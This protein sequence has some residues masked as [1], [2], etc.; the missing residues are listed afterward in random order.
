M[1]CFL[2]ID[3][4]TSFIKAA[5]IDAGALTLRGSVRQP[6]PEFLAGLSLKHRE[7]DPRAVM[8]AVESAIQGLAIDP[9]ACDGVVLC[10]QMHGFVLVDERGEAVSNYISW[11]DQ[12][13]SPE[14]FE[15]IASRVSENERAEL[16]N[17][18]RSSI[19]LSLLYWLRRH[20][21]LPEGGATPVSIADYVAGR[22]C[23]SPPIMEPTQ[24]AAFGALRLGT[25]DWHR[26]VIGKLGLEALRWPEVRPTG[27]VA[28]WWNNLPCYAAAGDQQ[29]ALAGAL[30]GEAELS[31]NI[32][33]GS[34][35]ALIAETPQGGPHQTRPYFDGRFLRTITHIPGG[36]ALRALVGLLTEL[37]GGDEEEAWRKI[38]EAAAAA[39]P[40]DLRAHIAFFPGPCGERGYLENLHEGNLSVAGVFRAVFE[41]MAR[42]YETCARRLDPE[43]LAKRVV[44]SGG[45]ARRFA[46]LRE[47]TSQRLALADRLS[48]HPEDTLF[49]MLVLGLGYS[50]RHGSV[51]EATESIAASLMQTR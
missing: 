9:A 48:P 47:L 49:G 44:F 15:E 39:G 40:T 37:G 16:G 19:A 13:V 17:E 1:P 33:T 43:R 50:G 21:Q 38:E 23:G 46:L 14:E 36:R 8:A 3:V 32:G 7:V 25:L 34:Q 5:L 51:R 12:R 45:V 42:N 4:G 35:A 10:G 22:L 27:A 2:G 28:G 29:C 31:V 26:E 30:L 41:S 6:F 18:F 24:A 11:L 20:G